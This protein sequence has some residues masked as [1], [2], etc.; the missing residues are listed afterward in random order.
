MCS[1]SEDKTHIRALY[2][3]STQACGCLIPFDSIAFSCT[4]IHV[5]IYI[6]T[7]N[8]WVI[9]LITSTGRLSS[10]HARQVK[11][12]FGN[13]NKYDKGFKFVS[14]AWDVHCCCMCKK[15]KSGSRRDSQRV[16]IGKTGGK[17]EYIKNGMKE[18]FIRLDYMITWRR[19]TTS[20]N[21]SSTG[22]TE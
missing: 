1:S 5:Y 12:L 7:K 17:Y 19:K 16:R 2:M 21:F 18:I 11:L 13:S 14:R 9:H 15:I 8:D 6:I 3:T 22:S 4:S 10:T 20:R